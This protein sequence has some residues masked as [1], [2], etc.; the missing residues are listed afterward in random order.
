MTDMR[1]ASLRGFADFLRRE[2]TRLTEPWIKA[3]FGEV[4]LVEAD[5]LTF[6]QLADHLPQ[7]FDDLCEA[8]DA[9]DLEKVEPVIERSA[10]W[11]K[12]LR[13][14]VCAGY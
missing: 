1:G 9:E 3:V 6:E 2:R 8:L 13:G 10:K 11:S 5:K 4:D 12:R 7:I 14:N